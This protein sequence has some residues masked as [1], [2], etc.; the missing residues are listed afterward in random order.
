MTWELRLRDW[1][2]SL[3]VKCLPS[4][5]KALG[6]SFSTSKTNKQINKQKPKTRLSTKLFKKNYVDT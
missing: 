4:M 1:R 3:V 2:V 6:L 5:C